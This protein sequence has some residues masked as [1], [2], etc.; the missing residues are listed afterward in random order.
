M[1]EEGRGIVKEW[2]HAS[3]NHLDRQAPASKFSFDEADIAIWAP[4]SHRQ[5]S[6]R[7]P[8][9]LALRFQLLLQGA[10]LGIDFL[11]TVLVAGAG[12]PWQP[13]PLPQHFFERTGDFAVPTVPTA[14]GG[15]VRQVVT[16]TAEKVRELGRVRK[17]VIVEFCHGTPASRAG[18]P[19]PRSAG[20]Q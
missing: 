17:G 1:A 2:K 9:S 13:L 8:R 5:P 4:L 10:N 11:Q 20:P 16:V 3:K 18:K 19:Q 7:W 6:S 12:L 14:V 15:R